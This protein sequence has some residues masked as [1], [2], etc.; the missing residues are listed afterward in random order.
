MRTKTTIAID[1]VWL[2]EIDNRIIVQSI[3]EQ[4]AKLSPKAVSMAGHVGQ[5]VLG[6][7]RQY[8][9]INVNFAIMGHNDLAARATVCEKVAAWAAQQGAITVN[10]RPNRQLHAQCIQYPTIANAKAWAADMTMIFR[11]YQQPYWEEAV[12]ASVLVRDTANCET[13]VTAQ[14]SMPTP[15]EITFTA[16]A[17]TGSITMASGSDSIYF[18]GLALQPGDKFAITHHGGILQATAKGKSVLGNRLSTSSDEVMLMP[19]RNTVTC[20]A[21]GAGDWQ[22]IARGRFV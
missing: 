5:H 21:D 7:E 15:L 13:V 22:I 4:A 18:F 11:A 1:G 14:G 9:D 8:L 19:G 2:H 12:P 17:A 20:T 10:Y 16:K 3:T 6:V